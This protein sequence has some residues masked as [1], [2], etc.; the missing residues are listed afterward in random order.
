MD[1][2]EK[3]VV[4]PFSDVAGTTATP[5]S[6]NQ[7]KK[8]MSA[9]AKSIEK[10]VKMLKIVLRLAKINAYTDDGE[11]RDE[12]GNVISNSNLINL[13][14]KLMVNEKLLVGKN[15]FLKLLHNAKVPPDWVTNED[16][17]TRLLAMYNS[18]QKSTSNTDTQTDFVQNQNSDF[19]TNVFHEESPEDQM[20]IN[21]SELKRKAQDQDY[22]IE[23]NIP[24]K[25]L[26]ISEPLRSSTSI[27]RKV[28]DKDYQHENTNSKKNQKIFEPLNKN[29]SIKRKAQEHYEESIPRK[30]P[31]IVSVRKST[32]SSK[33]P[34]RWEYVN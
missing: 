3:A 19:Q 4:V 14:Q 9:Y 30:K 2:S 11:I 18:G 17:K 13:L 21:T 28:Q 1:M 27:K 16:M 22:L 23:D 25:I 8:K 15:E 26:K 5:S 34:E 33:V 12:F 7:G 29:T 31:K 20:E 32:R 10:L 24:R 6:D